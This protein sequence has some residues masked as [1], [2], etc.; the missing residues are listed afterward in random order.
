M[1]PVPSVPEK[2]QRILELAWPYLDTRGNQ[3]HIEGSLAYVRLLL[4]EEGGDPDVVIP[5]VILHDTGWSEV[6]EELQTLSFGPDC[7]RPDL[8]RR[9]EVAGAEIATEILRTVGW[10]PVLSEHIAEIVI[11]HDSRVEALSL[12]DALVK[13]ADRLFRLTRCSF[14][15]NVGWF[16]VTP[17]EYMDELLADSPAWF[18]TETAERLGREAFADLHLYLEELGRAEGAA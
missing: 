16:R 3:E 17:Q 2:Y 11:G 6:P 18:F 7:P 10:D 1:L 4:A 9:H 8:N 5:G 15:L 14:D 13:D 12:E